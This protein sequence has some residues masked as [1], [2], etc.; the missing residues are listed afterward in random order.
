MLGGRWTTVHDGVT[1]ESTDDTVALRYHA[2]SLYAVISM[3]D[4]KKPVRVYLEQDGAPL[5]KD[6]AGVDAR[7][8]QQGAYVEV[9][10]PR[11][12]YLVKNAGAELPLPK[13]VLTLK[14]QGKGFMLHSFTYG[15][16]CQQQF[17]Q[18]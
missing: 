18:L 4:E 17:E 15:N 3:A 7:F 16:N 8:D 12:Y 6:D 5:K 13:H 11:M 10:A 14:P 1:S 2:R 9:T